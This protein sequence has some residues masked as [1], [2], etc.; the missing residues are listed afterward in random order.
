MSNNLRLSE[1]WFNYGLWSIACIFAWFLIGLGNTIIRDLSNIEKSYKLEQFID[2]KAATP[3]RQDIKLLK[4]EQPKINDKISLAQLK[5]KGR[6]N[7]YRAAHTTYNNWIETRNVT[8][9]ANQDDAVIQHTQTLERLKTL[10]RE[11][12]KEIEDLQQQLLSTQQKIKTQNT[13]LSALNEAAKKTLLTKQKWQKLR[14]FLYRLALTL[15]LLIIS[16]WLFKKKRKTPHW[17]FVWGFYIFASY[18][19]FIELV[20]YLPHYGGYVR[21]FVGI[22]LIFF[23]GRTAIAALTKYLEKQRITETMPEAKRREKLDYDIALARLEKSVCPGCERP[24]DLNTPENDFC[25]HCGIA[26]HDYCG[27]CNTRKN[28]FMKFCHKCGAHKVTQ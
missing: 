6:Q 23:I 2:T 1:K 22:V 16:V 17:P 25:R 10:E 7:D 18:T 5:L 19:F 9:L 21:Y 13:A 12:L 26:L 4:Q 15:P 20:P 28:A 27:G 11:A 8:D 14:I 3:L 24:T